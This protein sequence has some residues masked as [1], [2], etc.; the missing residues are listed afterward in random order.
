MLTLIELQSGAEHVEKGDELPGDLVWGR[1]W[2]EF[3]RELGSTGSKGHNSSLITFLLPLC[4]FWSSIHLYIY[5]NFF[6]NISIQLLKG[7]FLDAAVH[8]FHRPIL[9]R[10]RVSNPRIQ[11]F[12][13][14]FCL[15]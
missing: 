5:T 11:L 12:H 3:S 2:F 15:L 9:S 13:D 14:H 10:C 6:L 8:F 7:H 1:S 4:V